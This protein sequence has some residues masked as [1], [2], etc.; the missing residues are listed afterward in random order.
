MHDREK[1]EKTEKITEKKYY[2]GVFV[3]LTMGGGNC[4][5]KWCSAKFWGLR[6]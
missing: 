4:N 6:N 3:S 1:I 2:S 5:P